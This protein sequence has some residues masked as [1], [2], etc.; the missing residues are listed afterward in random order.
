[1]ARTHR[2]LPPAAREQLDPRPREARTLAERLEFRPR[3]VGVHSPAEAAVGRGD[4]ALGPDD[5]REALDALGDELGVLDQ[6]GRVSDDAWHQHEIVG[7][8]VRVLLPD[9]PPVL[10]ARVRGLE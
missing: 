8:Q 3:D 5:L 9:G 6:V 2:S 4:H 1:M 10:V 7:N